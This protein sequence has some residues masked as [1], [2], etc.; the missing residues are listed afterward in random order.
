MYKCG[1]PNLQEISTLMDVI[2]I[3]NASKDLLHTT[4]HRFR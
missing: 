4:A 2:K 3:D 1:E